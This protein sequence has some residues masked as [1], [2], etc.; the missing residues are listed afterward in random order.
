[1]M[2]II[3]DYLMMII[4]KDS[5]KTNCSRS[6]Y[7]VVKPVLMFLIF[8]YDKISEVQKSTKKH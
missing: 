7:K 1:M 4:K 5:N 3:D 6:I 8:F 2:I